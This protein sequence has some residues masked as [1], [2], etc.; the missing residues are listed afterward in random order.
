MKQ[1]HPLNEVAS[2]VWQE[3]TK[4]KVVQKLKRKKKEKKSK[5]PKMAFKVSMIFN[6]R[7]EYC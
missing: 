6:T 3:I 2:D 5:K 7:I 4:P 1:K